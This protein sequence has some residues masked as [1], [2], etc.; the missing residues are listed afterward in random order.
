M[1]KITNQSELIARI[2]EQ[3]LCLVYIKTEHCGVCDVVLDKTNTLLT[4]YPQVE[5]F[6]INM[7]E[8][9]DVSSAYLVFTAPTILLF[10]EGKEVYRAS[11]FVQMDELE[12]TISMWYE[13]FFS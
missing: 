4:K 6:L 10:I 3:S 5:S 1:N 2:Q 13:R 7:H 12:H 9:P 8:N 11:R